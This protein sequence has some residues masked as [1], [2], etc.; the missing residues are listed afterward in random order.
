LQCLHL[1]AAADHLISHAL[2][3]FEARELAAIHEPRID[4]ELVRQIDHYRAHRRMTEHDGRIDL[5]DIED[6]LLPDPEHIFNR[7]LFELA[8][9]HDSGVDE[10]V[11]RPM[12]AGGKVLQT[13]NPRKGGTYFNT[14]LFALEALGTIGSS[15]RRF[16]HGPG[17]NNWDMALLKD[18]KLTESKTLQF[19]F[20]AFNV[21]NH[22]QFSANNSSGFGTVASSG[23]GVISSTYGHPRILQ[24]G[25]KFLF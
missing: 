22:A 5:V 6:E 24:A 20:E 21:F 23:F 17:L 13:T 7:L 19:R 3:E 18:T 1:L 12:I 25:L 16:F 11:G 4:A 10:Q 9:R 15:R 2:T 14:S 8:R